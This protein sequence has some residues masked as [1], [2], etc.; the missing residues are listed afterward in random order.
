MSNAEIVCF[1]TRGRS[2]GRSH[3]SY[4]DDEYEE[5]ILKSR[6]PIKTLLEHQSSIFS[7]NAHKSEVT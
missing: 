4:F 7:S 5:M 1:H 6:A 2:F 3:N